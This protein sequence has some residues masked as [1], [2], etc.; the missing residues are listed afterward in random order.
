MKH[1]S[2]LCGDFNSMCVGG[3]GCYN[4]AQHQAKQAAG[5]RFLLFFIYQ[6][7]LPSIKALSTCRVSL[8]ISWSDF[9]MCVKCFS[10]DG[11]LLTDNDEEAVHCCRHRRC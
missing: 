6:L 1:I 9:G 10:P 3:L 4:Q 5:A 7:G 8:S 2:F 11:K